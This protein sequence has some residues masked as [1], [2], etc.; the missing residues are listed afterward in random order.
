MIITMMKER[1]SVIL[2]SSGLDKGE[3]QGKVEAGGGDEGESNI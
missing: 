3:G 1:E 2:V